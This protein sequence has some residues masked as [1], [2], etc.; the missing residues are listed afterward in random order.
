MPAMPPQGLLAA[1]RMASAA[2][3]WLYLFKSPTT[4]MEVRLSILFSTS[5]GRLMFSI[6]KLVSVRPS[7]SILG[8]S[9]FRAYWLSS[10]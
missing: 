7:T 4:P 1:S 6:T 2:W 8:L 9:A 10:S 5:S 3:Y